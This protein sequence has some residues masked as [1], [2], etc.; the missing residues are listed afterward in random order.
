VAVAAVL[1]SLASL[2]ASY[3]AGERKRCLDPKLWDRLVSGDPKQVAVAKHILCTCGYAEEDLKVTIRQAGQGNRHEQDL[4]AIWQPRLISGS[5]A[6]ELRA[7][8]LL[9]SVADARDCALARSPE[10]IEQALTI[11]LSVLGRLSAQ[12]RGALDPVAMRE[13]ER[14]IKQGAVARA[15]RML[16]T[17]FE[18]YVE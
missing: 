14:A 4:P 18:P 15:V 3:R 7:K 1:V 8:G 6:A 11:Y 16:A 13:S 9:K 5:A 10:Q 12:A 2:I 17:A